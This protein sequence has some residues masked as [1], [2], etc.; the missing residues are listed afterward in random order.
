MSKLIVI[1]FCKLSRE[2]LCLRVKKVCVGLR[3]GGLLF[4][5]DRFPAVSRALDASRGR[6]L[7]TIDAAIVR[8]VSV[9]SSS[10]GIF[11]S[12]VLDMV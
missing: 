9:L 8:G 6:L 3:S 4:W 2:R 1:D 12:A 11:S 5:T 10:S 7:S